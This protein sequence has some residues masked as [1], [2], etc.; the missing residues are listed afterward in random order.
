MLDAHISAQ[1]EHDAWATRQIIEAATALTAEEWRQPFPVGPGS[2]ERTLAHLVEAVDFFTDILARRAYA[3]R[4]EFRDGPIAPDALHRQHARASAALAATVEATLSEGDLEQTV[5][6]PVGSG[7][8]VPL[9]VA[10]TQMAD[11]GSHHRAQCLWMLRSLG[12]GAGLEVHPLRWS[13]FDP[14]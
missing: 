4:A 7:R 8:D 9:F 1:F 11:H 10:L 5:E 12:H 2:L 14:A 13:G 6:F 3:P